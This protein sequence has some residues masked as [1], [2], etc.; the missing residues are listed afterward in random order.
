MHMVALFAYFDVDSQLSFVIAADDILIRWPE[1][2]QC[3]YNPLQLINEA[4]K[5]KSPKGLFEI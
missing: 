1:V 5:N 2:K 4:F 3:V